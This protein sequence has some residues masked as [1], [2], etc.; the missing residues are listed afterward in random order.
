MEKERLH[1][2]EEVLGVG[3][4]DVPHQVETDADVGKLA[5]GLGGCLLLGPHEPRRL[6]E[7]LEVDAEVVGGEPAQIPVQRGRDGKRVVGHGSEGRA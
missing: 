6:V 4:R 5:D 2:G 3:I 1:L 7:P